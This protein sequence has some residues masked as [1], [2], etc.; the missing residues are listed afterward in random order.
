MSQSKARA[1]R[2]HVGVANPYQA[3]PRRGAPP[4]AGVT[5]RLLLGAAAIAATSLIVLN[6]ASELIAL[7]ASEQGVG[8][9]MHIRTEAGYVWLG[10]VEYDAYGLPSFSNQAMNGEVLNPLLVQS[11]DELDELVSALMDD[12]LLPAWL[13]G[14]DCG[15]CEQCLRRHADGARGLSA[16]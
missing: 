5:H 1:R 9:G 2:K 3:R 11:G 8:Y 7:L 4:G 12:E 15:L 10:A 16:A 14:C 13:V 6:S